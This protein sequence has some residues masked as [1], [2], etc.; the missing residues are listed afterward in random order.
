MQPYDSALFFAR[1]RTALTDVFG[2]GPD[3][4]PAY[5]LAPSAHGPIPTCMRPDLAALSAS[6][7]SPANCG[8][9]NSRRLRALPLFAALTSLGID[10]YRDLFVRNIEFAR[11]LDRYL[12]G[13]PDR[14]TTLIPNEKEV[15][16]IV[17]F[18]PSEETIDAVVVAKR[19]NEEGKIYVGK[20][21]WMGRSALRMAICNWQT[22]LEEDLK[23]VCEALEAA[24]DAEVKVRSG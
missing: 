18:R 11:G 15:G 20:T 17:L 2:P 8:I 9:E 22:T 5:L 19:I 4:P 14:W 10:G 1:S 16:N 6:L 24:L 3:G 23:V 21:D 7:P 12:R 13:R